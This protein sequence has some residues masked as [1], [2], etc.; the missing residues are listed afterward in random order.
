MALISIAFLSI[1]ILKSSVEPIK[2]NINS[3]GILDLFWSDYKSGSLIKNIFYFIFCLLSV[4][5]F[6]LFLSRNETLSKTTFFPAF[7]LG[8]L[9]L[10]FFFI[11]SLNDGV[12]ANLLIITGIQRISDSYRMETAKGNLFDAGF[13]FSL[14]ILIYPPAIT[15]LPLIFISISILR[16][17][18]W[19]EWTIAVIGIITP[20]LF[21]ISIIYLVFDFSF[22]KKISLLEPFNF[23]SWKPI[24]TSQYFLSASILF[25]IFLIV[26]RRLR[27]GAYSR[28]IRQQKNFNILTFW[29]ILGASSI[30]MDAPYVF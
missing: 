5:S 12:L 14:S 6:H 17:F 11:D 20:P 28:K 18:I 1:F 22:L 15:L 9:L 10:E 23:H 4:I 13:L 21:I 29:V 24:F 26:F 7:I 8:V 30:F 16:P 25:F 3:N 19:R 27:A 2:T